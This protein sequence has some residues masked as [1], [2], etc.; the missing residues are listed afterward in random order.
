VA[1]RER[2]TML[3][4]L[5]MVD[6]V[7]IFDEDEPYSLICDIIPDVLVKGSD[8]AHYVSGR[9]VVEQ[10][11]GRVFLAPLVQGASTTGIIEKVLAVFTEERKGA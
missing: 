11:G 3:A 10:H 7:V 9:D 1:E 8:W 4:A 6:Y 2:A 5:A